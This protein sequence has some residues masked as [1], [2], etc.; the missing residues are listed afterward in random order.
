MN[1]LCKLGIHKWKQVIGYSL[2]THTKV[3]ERCGKIK[4]TY[5]I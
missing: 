1:W 3:C 2:F 5:W 4:M